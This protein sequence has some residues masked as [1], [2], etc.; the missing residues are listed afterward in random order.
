MTNPTTAELDAA[1]WMAHA[2]AELGVTEVPGPASNPRILAYLSSCDRGTRPWLA[3]DQT[4][5]C[6]AFVNWCMQRANLPRTRSLGA[7]SWCDYG[8]PVLRAELEYGDIVVLW[9]GV[10]LSAARKNAPGHVAFFERWSTV[11]RGVAW[12]LGGNQGN[13]VH[14]APFPWSRVIAVRRPNATALALR[15]LERVEA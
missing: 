5:W 10:K 7:R 1:P 11:D 6:S 2:R 3:H 4:S 13:R 8:E 9:R 15:K 14:V 12:L